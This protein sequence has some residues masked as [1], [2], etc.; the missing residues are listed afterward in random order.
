MVT[1]HSF[2]SPSGGF[3]FNKEPDPQLKQL[4]TIKQ[5]ILP[6]IKFNDPQKNNNYLR[7]R[8]GYIDG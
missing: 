8:K 2:V 7:S 3:R 6:V 5:V 1:R 4:I